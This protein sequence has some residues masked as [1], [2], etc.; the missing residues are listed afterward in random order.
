[1]NVEGKDEEYRNFWIWDEFHSFLTNF[2][3]QITTKKIPDSFDN[4]DQ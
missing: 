4:E 3:P 2:K 1:M